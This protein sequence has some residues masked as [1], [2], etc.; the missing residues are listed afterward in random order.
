MTNKKT[1]GPVSARARARLAIA[2]LA[3]ERVARDKR[4]EEHATGW[5]QL[6]DKAASIEE[7]LRVVRAE[8]AELIGALGADD[9]NVEETAA[10][11]DVDPAYVRSLR[12]RHR[13]ALKTAP[14]TAASGSVASR[15]D[16]DTAQ[17]AV[18]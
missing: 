9:V 7:Q 11:L 5:Y 8:Q 15:T 4:I 12:K 14:E 2:A 13:D 3:A 10:L 17:D 1:V 6:V 18:A 16:T